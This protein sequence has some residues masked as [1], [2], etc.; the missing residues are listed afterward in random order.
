MQNDTSTLESG[1]AI[2]KSKFQYALSIDQEIQFLGFY[3]PPLK[4]K[5]RFTQNPAYECL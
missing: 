4:W 3:P 2:F 1:L 5:L